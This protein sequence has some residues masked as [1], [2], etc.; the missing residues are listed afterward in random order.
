[1]IHET[2]I[3]DQGAQIGTGVSIGAYT[4]IGKNVTI[5]D[6]TTIAP[7]VIINGHTRIGKN[8]KIFQFCSI[9][10]APQHLS[11]SGQA[12]KVVIGDNNIIREHCTIHRGTEEGRGCTQI[13]DHNMFMAY[14]HVAHD[15]LIG[16]HTIFA[17][18]ASLAGHV[19]VGDYVVMGGFSLVH[20]FCRVGAHCITGIGAV[21]LMDVPPYTIAAGNRATPHGINSKGLQRRDFNQTDIQELKKLFKLLYHSGKPLSQARHEAQELDWAS[22]HPNHFLSFFEGSRR[23]V[24][25]AKGHR[26]S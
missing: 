14:V 1:M 12:T 17:N 20:Q 25:H 21:C 22:N 6:G 9:G 3:I 7:H 13:S 19:D 15:C 16:S 10:E 24:M 11:Y 5:G 18:N 4:L 23:G 26:H 8:N 2:A